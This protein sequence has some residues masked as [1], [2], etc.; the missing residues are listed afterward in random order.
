MLYF[1]SL[2]TS[3]E[4]FN[5]NYI[6]DT[7]TH[8]YRVKR[9]IS[10]HDIIE[11]WWYCWLIKTVWNCG[12]QKKKREFNK[13]RFY[14]FRHLR[15]FI[16]MKRCISYWTT[17]ALSIAWCFI[18]IATLCGCY[19]RKKLCAVGRAKKSSCWC[20]VFLFLFFCFQIII[21]Y[22]M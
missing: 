21:F 11:K 16:W 5:R 20:H 7:R 13:T 19:G 1:L 4:F 18:F 3:N 22:N 12:W 15:I 9:A 10:W 8:L 2:D 17:S 6:I 14:I